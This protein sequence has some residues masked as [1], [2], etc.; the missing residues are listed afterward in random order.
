MAYGGDRV[1]LHFLDP[2]VRQIGR[3]DAQARGGRAANAAV[4]K[5]PA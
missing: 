5:A 1:R 3:S 4:G 2:E